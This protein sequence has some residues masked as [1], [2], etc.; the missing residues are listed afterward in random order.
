[1]DQHAF[2]QEVFSLKDGMYRFAKRLLI[3]EDEAKDVVQEILIKLWQMKDTLHQ[4]HN[5]SSFAMKC[6][7]N[8]CLNRLKHQEVVLKH[9]TDI[10]GQNNYCQISTDNT[11]EIILKMI[12]ALPEKQ[13][14]VIHLKDVEEYNVVEISETLDM[15]E[16]AVRV[17]LMR[18][19]QKI[20]EQLE[21]LFDY[22]NRR[23]QNT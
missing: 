3:S 12:D 20:K 9:Q 17:N 18:A 14:M 15:E 13:K 11:H 5:V 19:R 7:K 22:E 10:Y 6:I 2:K 23:I 21:R 16:S 8:E 1:M 4:Y